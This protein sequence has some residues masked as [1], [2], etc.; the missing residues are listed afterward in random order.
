MYDIIMFYYYYFI[1]F[2]VTCEIMLT[3][4]CNEPMTKH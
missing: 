4:L 3:N 1:T 2:F